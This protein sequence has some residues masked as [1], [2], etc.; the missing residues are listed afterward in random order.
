MSGGT[1]FLLALFW[2]D[3]LIWEFISGRA[4][5]A[6]TLGRMVA[7]DHLSTRQ[8]GVLLVLV[9]GSHCPDLCHL[10]DWKKLAHTTG[11]LPVNVG[12]LECRALRHRA[13]RPLG[14]QRVACTENLS[15]TALRWVERGARPSGPP[16]LTPTC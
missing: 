9:G 10:V 8:S 12:H 15:L 2:G 5:G 4:L 1:Q 11:A 3:V 16:V 13:A 14:P 6:W 7:S